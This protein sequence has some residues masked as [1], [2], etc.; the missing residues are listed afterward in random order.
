MNKAKIPVLTEVSAKS[1]KDQ[2]LAAYN[3][4]LEQLNAKQDDQ[5]STPVLKQEAH[6]KEEA[7]KITNMP[8]MEELSGLKLRLIKEV[9][10]LSDALAKETQKLTT[11]REAIRLEEVALEDTYRIGKTVYTLEALLKAH[12]EEQ[13]V[14]SQTMEI[15]TQEWQKKLTQLEA[16]YQ[17]KKDILE[18]N[19]QRE[20]EEYAYSTKMLRR[21][22][23][24]A[25]L[26]QKAQWEKE[27]A[28]Q[29]DGLSKRES[30]LAQKEKLL[31]E[32]QAKV[33]TFDQDLAQQ[34][35]QA[36]LLLQKR[37]EQEHK[38]ATELAKKDA[39][40]QLRLTEQKVLY[41]EAKIQEQ[42][43]F[44]KQLTHKADD[45]STQIQ[46]IA[47]RALDVSGQRFAHTLHTPDKDVA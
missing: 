39:D 23:E 41:L 22:E 29:Q 13:D 8:L 11:V 18:K 28:E 2:I 42:E 7:I 35:K 10:Q 33:D 34:V 47:C 38:F 3:Q 32:L 1:T 46:S 19:R 16:D 15:Q 21:K 6:V 44:I 17:E 12:K 40:S 14:F 9:D 43:Q 25:Y 5:M 20:A 4:A 36:E 30:V 45:A 24:D 31:C 27:M 37:L 26:A